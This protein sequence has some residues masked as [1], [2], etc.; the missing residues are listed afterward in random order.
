MR[1]KYTYFAAVRCSNA[2]ST[3]GDFVQIIGL[4]YRRE[5]VKYRESAKRGAKEIFFFKDL[6]PSAELF[7]LRY[8]P[9]PVYSAAIDCRRDK[10]IIN[11]VSRLDSNASVS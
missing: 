8:I 4:R 11:A 1:V 9:V 2:A 10:M 3:R 5:R 6:S 7:V